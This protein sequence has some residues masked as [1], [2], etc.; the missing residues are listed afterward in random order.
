MPVVRAALG[1]TCG[2]RGQGAY[3][4]FAGQ[5][6]EASVRAGV[7]SGT[8]GVDH[9]AA[10]WTAG[11][12]LS[13]S[14]P[15]GTYLRPLMPGGEVTSALT[16]AYP[17]AN[18]NLLPE[19]LA[20]WLS[21]DYGLGGMRVAQHGAEELETAI[22]LRLLKGTYAPATG[23]LSGR[24]PGPGLA[25]GLRGQALLVHAAAKPLEWGGSGWLAG[26]TP[27]DAN[28]SGRIEARLGYGPPAPTGVPIAVE[29]TRRENLLGA[30]PEHTVEAHSTM[31][32]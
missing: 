11:L 22:G 17:F 15:W 5:R 25:A 23:D 27:A 4:Q 3:G 29:P 13:H 9:A 1:L 28:P 12:A 26:A 32:S 30:A 8:L 6:D 7:A 20:P 18:C 16:G 31:R 14:S 19:R 24:Y 10:P 2:G 21:R